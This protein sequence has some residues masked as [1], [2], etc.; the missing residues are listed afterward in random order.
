MAVVDLIAC[1]PLNQK[2]V[3]DGNS[4]FQQRFD[5]ST[6]KSIG[7]AVQIFSEENIEERKNR[8]MEEG[9]KMM[10]KRNIYP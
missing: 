7:T 1:F 2:F 3:I 6:Y 9:K 10:E 5:F 8:K 4:D